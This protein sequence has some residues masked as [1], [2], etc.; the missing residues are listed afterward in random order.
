M[1]ARAGASSS[2]PL[3]QKEATMRPAA[4]RPAV[5]RQS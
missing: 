1:T 5:A 2:A 4:V 3:A